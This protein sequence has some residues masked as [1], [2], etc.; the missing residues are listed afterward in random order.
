MAEAVDRLLDNV[1][2]N[3]PEACQRVRAL[4]HEITIDELAHIG[5]RRNFLSPR[6]VQLASWLVRPMFRAFFRGISESPYLFDV[7]QM[8]QDALAFDYNDIPPALLQRSWV[9]TYCRPVDEA[10]CGAC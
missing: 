4:L 8:I 1:F 9:P 6:G 10:S 3:E 7:T 2:S 5:Q